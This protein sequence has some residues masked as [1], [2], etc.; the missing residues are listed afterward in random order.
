LVPEAG[1]VAPIGSNGAAARA[2]ISRLRVKVEPA[3]QVAPVP[4]AHEGNEQTRFDH[5]RVVSALVSQSIVALS[6][7]NPDG[8]FFSSYGLIVANN[9]ILL[10]THTVPGLIDGEVSGSVHIRPSSTHRRS[11]AD[12]VYRLDGD[13]QGSCTF[14]IAEGYSNDIAVMRLPLGDH[15]LP[16][17]RNLI[18]HFAPAASFESLPSDG[19]I[20]CPQGD[21]VANDV[22]VWPSAVTHGPFSSDLVIACERVT[23]PGDCGCPY[24][25]GSSIFAMHLGSHD[26]SCSSLAVVVPREVVSALV[27]SLN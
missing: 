24:F 19:V 27:N 2:R 13:P 11:E 17:G 21:Y 15:R 16:Y 7:T 5:I 4:I 18:A 10:M 8:T 6:F 26:S 1:A 3:R 20:L 22:R 14:V 9:D 12:L 25:L 23:T